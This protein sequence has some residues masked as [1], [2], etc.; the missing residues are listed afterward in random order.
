MWNTHRFLLVSGYPVLNV[1]TALVSTKFLRDFVSWPINGFNNFL[2][3]RKHAAPSHLGKVTGERRTVSPQWEE[4]SGE[5]QV[6]G[7]R[8][9]LPGRLSTRTYR[10]KTC[11]EVNL[12]R[13]LSD[14]LSSMKGGKE[15]LFSRDFKPRKHA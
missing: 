9:S 8:H 14:G 13:K 12:Q 7:D 11:T 6:R 10:P 5:P 3:A 1:P 4:S 2:Y 15:L